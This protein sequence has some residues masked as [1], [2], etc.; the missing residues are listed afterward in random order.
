MLRELR[1]NSK[2]LAKIFLISKVIQSYSWC[3]EDSVLE[4]MITKP[5][6]IEQ[7]QDNKIDYKFTFPVLL[8]VSPSK[9]QSHPTSSQ[10]TPCVN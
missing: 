2:L 3:F 10:L 8:K 5:L 9:S 4:K 6:I 7:P 1:L